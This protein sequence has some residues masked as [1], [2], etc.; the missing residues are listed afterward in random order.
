[1][2]QMK[3]N[4]YLKVPVKEKHKMKQTN[5]TLVDVKLTFAYLAEQP[6]IHTEETI[7]NISKLKQMRVIYKGKPVSCSCIVW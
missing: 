2:R 4:S 7:G 3:P 5:H 1:M 6:I